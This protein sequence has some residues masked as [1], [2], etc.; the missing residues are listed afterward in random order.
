MRL[1]VKVTDNPYLK[2][3]TGREIKD[4]IWY[5]TH[6]DTKYTKVASKLMNGFNIFDEK[7]YMMVHCFDKTRIIEVEK[8]DE[9]YQIPCDD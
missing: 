2:S 8:R 3:A 5:N 6:Y 7:Y 9:K 4:W 1:K